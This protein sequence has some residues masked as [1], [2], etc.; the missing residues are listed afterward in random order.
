[1]TG[2]APS[3]KLAIEQQPRV[4]ALLRRLGKRAVKRKSAAADEL[5]RR[6]EDARILRLIE[7]QAAR[8]VAGAHAKAIEAHVLQRAG[9]GQIHRIASRGVVQI[10][11]DRQQRLEQQRISA[12]A[13]MTIEQRRRLVSL[14]RFD[15]DDD[16]RREGDERDAQHAS[17]RPMGAC[18]AMPSR[19]TGPQPVSV[20]RAP[21][22]AA[23]PRRREA[24]HRDERERA[25][26]EKSGHARHERRAAVPAS[27]ASGQHRRR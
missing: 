16:E 26:A 15:R 25:G 7:I 24:Q 27:S 12:A 17:R 22:A 8:V 9:R 20:K 5:R 23:Q 1:M 19:H 4:G 18:C 21:A 3:P 6:R 14:E 10:V 13:G 11:D 2:I